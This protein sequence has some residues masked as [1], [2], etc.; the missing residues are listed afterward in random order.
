MIRLFLLFF[1]LIKYLKSFLIFLSWVLR[2]LKSY[3]ILS[4][5]YTLIV[6]VKN[7]F[8]FCFIIFLP[9]RFL[10][11]KNKILDNFFKNKN[12][13]KGEEEVLLSWNFCFLGLFSS[14]LPRLNRSDSNDS[15][16]S[17][18]TSVNSTTQNRIVLKNENR[19]GGDK[20]SLNRM[21]VNVGNS[22]WLARNQSAPDL[23][24]IKE[25]W[26]VITNPSTPDL[27]KGRIYWSGVRNW[28]PWS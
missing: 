5:V 20:D 7:L 15:I 8:Y 12:K 11:L 1:K 23:K 28:W 9:K 21:D 19:V 25:A 17:S 22:Y 24:N 3:K 2:S 27:R 14:C 16:K 4:V 13:N 10:S 26:P 6:P 18:T